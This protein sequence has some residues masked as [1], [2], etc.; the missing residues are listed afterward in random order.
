MKESALLKGDAVLT[1]SGLFL[2]LR[3]RLS[4][5]ELADLGEKLEK[6]PR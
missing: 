1:D 4:T 6:S 5:R 2:L 3:N